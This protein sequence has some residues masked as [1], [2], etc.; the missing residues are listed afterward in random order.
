MTHTS[1]RLRHADAPL[2]NHLIE[3]ISELLM[4]RDDEVPPD[5]YDRVDYRLEI[6]FAAYDNEP[7]DPGQP[8]ADLLTD[9]IHLCNQKNWDL[10]ALL[11]RADKM[12]GREWDEWGGER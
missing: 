8:V 4:S 11:E 9:L 6:V 2:Q 12:A 10:Y 3:R 5:G 1:L 7:D